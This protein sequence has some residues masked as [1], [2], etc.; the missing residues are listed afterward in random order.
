MTNRWQRAPRVSIVVPASRASGD[1]STALESVLGQ[2]FSDFEVIVVTDGSPDMTDCEA[3]LEPYAGRI[4]YVTHENR[5]AGAARN[6]GIRQARGAYIALLDSDDRWLPEFLQR[7]LAYLDVHPECDVVYCDAL[8]TGDSPLAGRRVM[9]AAPSRGEVTLESLIAQRCNVIL[10]TVVA[11]RRL[12]TAVGL[13]DET[14][15]GGHDYELWLRAAHLGATIQFRKDALAE[16]RVRTDGLPGDAIAEL[17]RAIAALERFGRRP[18]LD[19]RARSA[20]RARL[21]ALVD[22]VEIEQG[23][24]RIVEGNFAAARYHLGAAR[25]QPWKLRVARLALRVAPRLLRSWCLRLRPP[26]WPVHAPAS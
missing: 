5:G 3:G 18:D 4:H 22:R 26:V 15:R 13:F 16:L 7:Q 1:I 20:V 10:P 19:P 21:M 25:R 17:Q 9:S 23:K 2:T 11:R 6:A 12:L 14:L 8:V 24:R